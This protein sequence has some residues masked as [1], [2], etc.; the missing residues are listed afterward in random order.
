MG[1][2][3]RQSIKYSIISFTGAAVGMISVLFIYPLA[4]EAVGFINT[5][6]STAM[7]LVPLFNLGLSNVS[8]KFFNEFAPAKT[9][10]KSAFVPLLLI[11]LLL[12]FII[13]GALIWLGNDTFYQILKSQ[14]F[15][16]STI[17][18]NELQLLVFTL[19][20][21]L[22]GIVTSLISNSQRIV[23]PNLL[24]N[25]GFKIFL[26]IIILTIA[27]GYQNTQN[28]SANVIF[29]HIFV[30]LILLFYLNSLQPSSTSWKK[31]ELGKAKLK[32]MY[33][34]AFY[35]GLTAL[36]SVLAYRID[37][38]MI[39]GLINYET[40][41]KYVLP[42]T[43]AAVMDIPNMAINSISGPIISTAWDKKD[44]K[45]IDKLYRSAAINLTIIGGLILLGGYY[46]FDELSAISSNPEVFEGLKMVFL[47]LALAK[48]VDM[49]TSINSS[50]LGYSSAYKF[51]LLFLLVLA[52]LNIVFNLTFIPE[53]G[54]LG[55]CYATALSILL[56]N[57]IKL[58]FL[59]YKFG[60]SPFTWP[61]VKVIGLIS[62]FFVSLQFFPM[63]SQP[64]VSIALKATI[65]STLY[66]SIIYRLKV[67]SEFNGIVLGYL[68][69]AKGFFKNK[70]N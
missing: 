37:T 4:I 52:V 57:G 45:E 59:Y 10:T 36:G 63:L 47:I 23:V 67:S 27:F 46:C 56:Y 39:S 55:A 18:E 22:I 66:T 51:N 38:V 64:I 62:L 6:I 53:F 40:A 60:L 48:L 21:T 28:L 70:S 65:I 12:N 9:E 26:P 49:I 33:T 30:L 7:I 61:L 20:L 50:I 68:S 44:F 8:I 5:F 41:G 2:I 34:F 58:I 15:D 19:L 14:N 32:E 54:I 29:Y 42:M 69:K 25:F 13:I 1:I 3:S 35:S 17:Q 24:S 31:P 11:L 16:I 43:M